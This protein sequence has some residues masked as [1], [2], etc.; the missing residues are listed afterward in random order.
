MSERDLARE[1]EEVPAA[2]TRTWRADVGDSVIGR[3]YA[4]EQVTSKY[5]SGLQTRIVIDEDETGDLV[6][7]YCHHTVMRREI[8]K[9]DPR[10][11]DR[12]GIKRLPDVPGKPYRL[13]RVV[14]DRMAGP[15]DDPDV[16][17][18]E[19]D[20]DP[21]LRSGTNVADFRF[22]ANLHDEPS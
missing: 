1:L 19:D 12:I 21:D 7:I 20:G 5:G 6:A 4:V 17:V 8:E 9:Q 22:G 13:Y 10:V 15:D 16:A 3:V 11:G 14:V 18:S 2:P